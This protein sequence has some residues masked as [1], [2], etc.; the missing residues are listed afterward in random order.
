MHIGQGTTAEPACRYVRTKNGAG[1]DWLSL[2]K[3]GLAT[4]G[5]PAQ[6]WPDLDKPDQAL[7]SVAK[8]G[9]TWPSLAKPPLAKPGQA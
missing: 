6:A 5:K 7:R 3:S 2:A 4:P 9:Q 1:R 8:P